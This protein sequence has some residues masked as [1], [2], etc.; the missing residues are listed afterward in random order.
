VLPE[1]LDCEDSSR[2]ATLEVQE[3]GVEAAFALGWR[4]DFGMRVYI[5]CAF[6][7]E[8]RIPELSREVVHADAGVVVDCVGFVED[9]IGKLAERLPGNRGLMKESGGVEER[10]DAL[11]LTSQFR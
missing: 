2:K 6:A 11:R 4:A 9:G 3:F 5:D 8:I 7:E 1:E 10:R